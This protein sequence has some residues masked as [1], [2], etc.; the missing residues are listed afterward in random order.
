VEQKVEAFSV[1]ADDYVTKPFHFEEIGA[2]IESLIQRRNV[3][4]QMHS[5]IGNL[6]VENVELERLLTLD[7]KT[8]LFNFREFRRKLREEWMRSERYG[9]PLSLVLF[10]L[11]NFKKFNDTYGHRAGD[12][13]LREFSTLLAGGARNTDMVARY[14]GEEF[15]MILP[16]TDTQM[17]QRVAERIRAAVEDFIFLADERPARLLVS[18]GVATYP[19]T[20][21]VD[22][23]DTLVEYA[24]R[25]LYKA[26]DSG[27]NVV[28][29]FEE[30]PE[31]NLDLRHSAAYR[32]RTSSSVSE[33][34]PSRRLD[35]N[36]PPVNP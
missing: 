19:S 7:E 27:R 24:D 23:V 10:D 3:Y 21:T 17:A 6:Q 20:R 35:A 30:S 1:G 5:T 25:A 22:S 28:L 34:T 18:G 2:R 31:E 33:S 16:H 32:S 14:G 13:A 26:K 11:D 4:H 29:A 12:T 15:A 8:G 36:K 9:A